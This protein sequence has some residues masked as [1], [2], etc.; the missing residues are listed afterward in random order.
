[1]IERIV[2][3]KLKPE[4]LTEAKAIGLHTEAVLRTLDQVRD[5]ALAPAADARTAGAWDIMIRLKFD[6]LDAVDAYL[7]DPMHRA[8]VDGFLKPRVDKIRAFNFGLDD[9]EGW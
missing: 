5:L 1:M 2:L 3:L 9:G 8:L 4:F 6:D 7:P